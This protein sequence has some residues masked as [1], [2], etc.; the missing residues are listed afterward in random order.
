DN[1][2]F[3]S[4][5]PL[6]GTYYQINYQSALTWHQARKSCQQQNA[7]LLSVTEIHEQIYLR[8]LI[9][10]KRSSLW[11]GL[12]SLNLNSGWQW[13]GGIPFRYFNWAQGRSPEPEPEKLCAVLNP[14]RDAKWEN[15]PCE[16]KVGYIC[17]KENSTLDPFIL[18]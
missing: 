3:W 13:S 1:D 6:T 5:D 12:N 9:D 15:Q 11:I 2:R 7:E 18:P 4:A 10:S 17:K 16:L 8:D 14:R